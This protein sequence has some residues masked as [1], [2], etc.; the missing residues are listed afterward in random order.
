MNGL[1]CQCAGKPGIGDV[2]SKIKAVFLAGL[3]DLFSG[4]NLRVGEHELHSA[5]IG[6]LHVLHGLLRFDVDLDDVFIGHVSVVN[7]IAATHKGFA[8]VHRKRALLLFAHSM[9]I[10]S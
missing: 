5:L 8:A 2:Q 4:A 7:G 9:Q 6:N 10:L 3:Y 1:F